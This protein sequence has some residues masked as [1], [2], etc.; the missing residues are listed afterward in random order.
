MV[1]KAVMLGYHSTTVA[2]LLM[3]DGVGG[4]QGYVFEQR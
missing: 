3:A 2:F 4:Q 1:C